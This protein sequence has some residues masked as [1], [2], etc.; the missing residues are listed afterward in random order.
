[1]G[2]EGVSDQ[3]LFSVADSSL[4]PNILADQAFII[5]VEASR[6]GTEVSSAPGTQLI[7]T[8]SLKNAVPH[9]K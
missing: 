3:L 1:M 8:V 4:P 2:G 5:N 7:A 9:F 6:P